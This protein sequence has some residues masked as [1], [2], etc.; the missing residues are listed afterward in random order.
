[1]LKCGSFTLQVVWGLYANAKK[2]MYMVHLEI[3]HLRKK[4]IDRVKNKRSR[5]TKTLLEVW[6]NPKLA[7]PVSFQNKIFWTKISYYLNGSCFK[8]KV[9]RLRIRQPTSID[10]SWYEAGVGI[11]I[12]VQE[13]VV[14]SHWHPI[15]IVV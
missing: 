3:N 13:K 14:H 5:F 11:I 4:T 1:M 10:C 8:T 7:L 2:S 9:G 6:Q 12:V 15:N